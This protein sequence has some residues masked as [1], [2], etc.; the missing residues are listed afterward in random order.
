M[1]QL[2]LAR[3]DV[4]VNTKNISSSR[5]PLSFAAQKGHKDVV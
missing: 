2:L 5:T 1:V 4:D 3:G